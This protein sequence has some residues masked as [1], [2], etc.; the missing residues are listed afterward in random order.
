MKFEARSMKLEVGSLKHEVGS[1]QVGVQTSIETT[2]KRKN[3]IKS[4]TE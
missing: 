1:I 4:E 3:E 2:I